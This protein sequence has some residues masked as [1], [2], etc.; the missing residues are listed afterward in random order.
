M[1]D[2]SGRAGG[3]RQAAPKKKVK[4][5]PKDI[6]PMMEEDIIPGLMTVRRAPCSIPP[7]LLVPAHYSAPT[8]WRLHHQGG[9]GRTQDCPP[10]RPHHSLVFSEEA[11]PRPTAVTR[12]LVLSVLGC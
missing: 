1:T 9:P 5:P 12:P 3:G 6:V 4:A 8:P 2:A 10:P 11:A 7:T